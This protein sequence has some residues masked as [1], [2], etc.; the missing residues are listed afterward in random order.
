MKRLNKKPR[1]ILGKSSISWQITTWE[2]PELY[3][4]NN[5]RQHIPSTIEKRWT[6]LV[7][8]DNGISKVISIRKD[9]VL[10]LPW[11]LYSV[12]LV[13]NTAPERQAWLNDRVAKLFGIEHSPWVLNLKSKDILNDRVVKQF[14]TKH[15]PK[16]QAW[17]GKNVLNNQVAKQFGPEYYLSWWV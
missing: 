16:C 13:Q 1:V 17:K 9:R 5:L 6:M 7:H 15:S 2:R 11:V 14:G 10:Q 12:I 4:E 3:R 8:M